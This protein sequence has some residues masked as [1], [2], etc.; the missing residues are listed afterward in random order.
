[1]KFPAYG[2]QIAAYIVS[3]LSH[4]TGGRIDFARIWSRQAISPEFEQLIEA[5][6]PQM[7]A[8]MRACAGQKNPSEWYKKEECWNELQTQLPSFTDPLPPEL[9][10]TASA[11]GLAEDGTPARFTA[12]P[13]V[14]A[15]DY[16]R[17]AACMAISS[18][19]WMVVAERG[20]STGT[21]HWKVA[22]ICRTIAG[23]AAG[24]WQRKP[25]AKQAKPA[26]DAVHAVREAGLITAPETPHLA[27]L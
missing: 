13:G 20:Q 24:N 19:T 21:I 3:G 6:A 23:Y 12:E 18:A 25:S 15:A 4:R 14:S 5:W 7:D 11:P 9:S 27:K 16:E 8:L 1:M 26:L 17:I 10:Y 2:A 22:G